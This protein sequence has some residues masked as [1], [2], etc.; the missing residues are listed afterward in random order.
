[1]AKH[2]NFS[3]LTGG[4]TGALDAYDGDNLSDGDHG[5]V[6]T[7]SGYYIYD[8]D[9]SSG[10][11]E[12]S[13]YIIAPDL[14][15]GTKRWVLQPPKGSFSHVRAKTGV[16]STLTKTTDT[17]VIFGTE[18]YDDLGEY[19]HTTGIFTPTYAGLYH[20]CC[21]VRT[22]SLSWGTGDSA[23]MV[24]YKGGVE[25]TRSQAL[26][27]AASTVLGLHPVISTTVS[28]TASQ[29]LA[30]YFWHNRTVGDATIF[31]SDL[32]NWITID[33]IV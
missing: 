16:G 17:L 23:Y 7:D 10:A 21:Q 9:A 18:E 32:Y 20:V 4:G 1:M 31:T 5:Y 13:P 14:N 24:L 11:S 3:A 12:N 8:L 6:V 30:P 15:P 33:R 28:L 2:L 27:S 26:Y 25:Y 19:D 29:T 22:A